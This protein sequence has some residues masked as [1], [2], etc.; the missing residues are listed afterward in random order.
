MTTP[1]QEATVVTPSPLAG[2]RAVRQSRATNRRAAPKKAAPRKAT[3]SRADGAAKKGR[4]V[5]RIVG[6]VKAGCAVLGVRA[7]VQ[8]AIIES[9]AEPIAL[10]LERVANEDKRVDALLQKI[11]SIF[12]K[13]TAWSELAGE[14]V[15]L[16]AAL[17]LS[18]GVVPPGL[19]GIAIAFLGGELLDAG[20]WAAARREAAKDLERFGIVP[21]VDGYDRAFEDA[22]REFYRS[23]AER[24]PKPGTQPADGDGDQDGDADETPTLGIP[25]PDDERPAW[26]A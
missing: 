13:G 20:L 5:D 3:T 9:R 23:F 6:S 25:V 8:A 15:V 2:L 4:Y 17:T 21:G 1:D 11:S 18:M 7:P 12:G 26:A 19:P 10:A 22:T 24:I 14:G 16:G